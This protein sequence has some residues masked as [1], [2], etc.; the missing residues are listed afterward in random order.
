MNNSHSFLL[1]LFDTPTN[2]AELMSSAHSKVFVFVNILSIFMAYFME[3]IH[4]ELA[5]EGREVF[6]LEV[7]RQNFFCEFGNALNVEG[8]TG[9]G[10]TKNGLDR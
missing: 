9:G 7:F 3:S 4:V 1:L 8:I 2:V 6:M 10:P 5:D